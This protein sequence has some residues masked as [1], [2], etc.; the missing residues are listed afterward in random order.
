[1]ATDRMN[2]NDVLMLVNTGTPESPVYAE[3]TGQRDMSMGRTRPWIDLGAK[4]DDVEVGSVG[5]RSYPL[6]VDV[7]YD[8]TDTAYLALVAAFE[9][10]E[11][12]L[13]RRSELGIDVEEAEAHILDMTMKAPQEAA[14]VV[15][16]QLRVTGG[17]SVVGS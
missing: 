13:V 1:M 12:I 14:S 11:T 16:V 3:L 10:K 15:A 6:T 4:G 9:A 17:W 5:R 2:G 8:P 7:I